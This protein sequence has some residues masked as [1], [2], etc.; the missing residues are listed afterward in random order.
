LGTLY[1]VATPIGNLEDITL[2]ALRILKEVTLIAAEDTRQTR[3]LLSAH[4]I[5]TPLESYHRHSGPGKREQ[6]LAQLYTQDVALVSDAGMPGISDPGQ[7]LISAA[8]AA[9]IPVVPVPGPSAPVTAVVV[10]GLPADRFLFLGFLPRTRSDRRRLLASIAGLHYT[11]V[12]FEA[13]HRLE[14][15]LADLEAVL[16]DRPAAAGRELTKIHEEVVRGRISD[17]RALFHERSP[18]GEFT[19]VVGPHETVPGEDEPSALDLAAQAHQLRAEGL[20]GKDAVRRL[21]EGTGASR[22]DAYQAWLDSA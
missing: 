5:H 6:L 19:L 12:A 7:E 2:R 22:R 10:S 8:I 18:R 9:G 13:P 14:A 17:L 21:M 20:L 15:A 11:L 4:Q 3:K 16:G 1:V